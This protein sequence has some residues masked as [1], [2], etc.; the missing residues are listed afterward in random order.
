VTCLPHCKFQTDAWVDAVEKCLAQASRE[1]LR[2]GCQWIILSHDPPSWTAV[3]STE[4]GLQ[5]S[6]FLRQW[7]FEFDPD[8][9]FSGHLHQSPFLS[10]F[11]D[12]IERTFCINPGHVRDASFP[13]HVVIDTE[14][15]T[16]V[17][18]HEK[19]GSVRS[20]AVDLP[21]TRSLKP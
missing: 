6:D 2:L 21:S 3:A 15:G 1:R 13:T 4:D 19:E 9:V 16:A 17:F 12:R 8:F 10:R 18:H 11:W 20:E 5:G 7:I 14:A